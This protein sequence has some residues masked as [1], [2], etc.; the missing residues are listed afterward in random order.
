MCLCVCYVVCI[1]VCNAPDL[2]APRN[3]FSDP[4]L[5]LALW[6]GSGLA[7]DDLILTLYFT[8]IYAL[9]KNIGADGNASEVSHVLCQPR[10]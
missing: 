10:Q 6:T 2:A 1:H 5:P 7:A 3:R 9:A 8:A 4:N